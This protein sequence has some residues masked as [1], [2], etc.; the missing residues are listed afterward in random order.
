VAVNDYQPRAPTHGEP[1]HHPR[2]HPDQAT[3]RNRSRILRERPT[4]EEASRGRSRR[5]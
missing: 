2:D 3:S 4:S 5:T 1:P